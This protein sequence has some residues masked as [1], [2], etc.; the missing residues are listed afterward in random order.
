MQK[1]PQ[2]VNNFAYPLHFLRFYVILNVYVLVL[3]R[4]HFPFPTDK[5]KN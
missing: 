2:K 3:Y 4:M 5:I 1:N